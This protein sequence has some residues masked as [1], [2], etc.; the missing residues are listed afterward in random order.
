MRLTIELD[1][2]SW[3]YERLGE[4]GA[5]LRAAMELDLK[6]KK[7]KIEEKVRCSCEAN[8]CKPKL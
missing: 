7:E 8:D 2:L 6:N 4:V 5:L 1:N 3:S